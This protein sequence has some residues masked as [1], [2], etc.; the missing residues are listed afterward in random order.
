MLARDP[1]A[2]EFVLHEAR[3]NDVKF[4]R[5]WFA[6]IL[7]KL[8]GFAITVEELEGALTRGMGFDGS[9]IEGFVRSDERDLYALPDPN[10]FSILPWRPRTNAVARMFCD[11]ITPDDE[12]F[13][14]DPRAVLRRNLKRAS[15]LGYTYYVAPEMEYFYFEDAQGTKGLD[16][17]SYFDQDATDLATDLRRET[18]LMLEELGIPVESSHHE[19]APS[20]HEIDL[21]HTDALTM[22]DTVMTYRLVVKEVARQHGYFA[23]FMP[24][25]DPEINGNGMHTHQSLF[26]GDSNAFYDAE[27][28]YHLSGVAKY[29]ISGLMRHAREIT[30]VTN[31]WVNSYK[32]LVPRF[33]A[34]TYVSWAMVNRSDLIRVPA[35]KPGREA[36]RRIE[37]RA[38]DPACNPYLAFSVMLAAGLQGIEQKY[39]LPPPVEENVHQMSPEERDSQGIEALPRN[40]WEAIQ[41]AEGSKLVRQALGDE[42]F[43]SFIENKKI[44]WESY[45]SHV[46]NFEIRRYLPVL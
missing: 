2:I 36:S 26:K 21:R 27:D 23:S 30:A 45:H 6:D 43:G 44:E 8:K 22:A 25:P 13:E 41:I 29:F 5:L 35:Y 3:E 16:Q 40:L 32:R 46:G 31:Q 4:I 19:V 11:I 20:Q 33:E 34:P 10:T 37:Y 38:P 18:V 9:A 14:G 39:E 28:A 7:G 17:G 1:E 12:P 15:K 42:V 24:K